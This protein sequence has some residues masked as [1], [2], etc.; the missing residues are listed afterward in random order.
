[1]PALR[2]TRTG[3]RDAKGSV[4]RVVVVVA[5]LLALAAPGLAQPAPGGSWSPNTGWNT[6]FETGDDL[7]RQHEERARKM[8]ED[9]EATSKR[10]DDDFN[11]TSNIVWGMIVFGGIAVVLIAIVGALSS[12]RRR[13][14]MVYEPT[15]EPAY[16]PT[17]V[18]TGN[19]DVTVLRLAIDGRASKFVQTELEAIV[20]TYDAATEDSRARRLR[21]LSI[22]LRRVRDS[23]IYGGADNDPLRPR[24]EALAAVARHVDEARSRVKQPATQVAGVGSTRPPVGLILVSIVV[25]ARGELM[26]VT[27]LATGEDIRRALEAAVDRA[28]SD[29]LAVEVVWVP[30]ETGQ[31][32][33]SLDLEAHYRTSELHPLAG[34]R[35]G[36]TFC[37]YC[38]G[39]FPMELVSCPHCGAPAREARAS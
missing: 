35:V 29:L 7:V 30:T 37:T 27:D 20:K 16:S 31:Q 33:S 12:R 13:P 23:W 15:L 6:G 5:L 25:A 24:S 9:F 32:L 26:T 2:R 8:R 18:S 14:V 1:M 10:M 11:R 3:P 38:G 21:E 4:M 19:I 36:K 17:P 39:P 34:S 28:A 22:M